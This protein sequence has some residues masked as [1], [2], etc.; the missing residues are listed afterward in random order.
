MILG[1]AIGGA[2]PNVPAWVDGYQ[3]NA[4]G[5]VLAAMLHPAGGFGRFVTVILAFSMVG[6][7]SATMYSITLNF[8]MFFPLLFRI[9]RAVFPIVISG[10]VIGV[11]I[12]AAKSFFVNLENFIGIIGYWSAAFI[13]IVLVEH[14]IFRRRNFN[15]YIEDEDAWDDAKKLPPGFAAISA[16]IFSLG[17][18]IPGMA[19][20]WYTGPIA[21]R[22][23]DIGLEFALVVSAL[24]YVP[25]RFIE[26]KMYGR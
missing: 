16:A 20:I 8:Q 14:I 25:L 5:G 11:A 15:S 3:T 17:L 6:N 1:A 9:P 21:K 26:R 13:G 7:L 12:E 18:V 22:T 24:L 23:G 4:A 2:T 19:Q 10:I